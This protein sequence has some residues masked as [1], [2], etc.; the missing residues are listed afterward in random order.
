MCNKKVKGRQ[1]ERACCE[2]DWPGY[3]NRM[4]TRDMRVLTHS[5]QTT[6]NGNTG[7]IY[8][9]MKLHVNK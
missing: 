9:L 2:Q 4:N 7:D 1:S 8:D 6:A 3:I 5:C